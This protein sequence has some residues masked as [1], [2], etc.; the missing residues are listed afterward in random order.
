MPAPVLTIAE[1]RAWERQSWEAGAEEQDVIRRVG[2]RLAQALHGQTPT[3]SRILVVAGRGNNG[4]DAL[5]AA[6][7]LATEFQVERLQILS[8][9]TQLDELEAALQ[10]RPDLLVDGLFGIGLN[11]PLEGPWLGILDRM[12]ASGI[13]IA[14]VDVPSGLD[15]DT[16]SPLG[17]AIRATTTFTVGAPKVG[18][19]TP[20][21]LPFVGRLEVLFD[22]GLRGT[23]TGAS[24]LHW[25][26]PG[27]FPELPPRRVDSHKGSHGHALVIAGSIG[28]SGAA[29]LAARAATRARPGLVS[30]LTLPEAWTP[31]AS[32]LVTAMVHPFEEGHALTTGATAILIGPGLASSSARQQMPAEVVRLWKEFPGPLVVDASA[33]DWVPPHP[34]ARGIRILTPHPGEAGRLLGG[35]AQDVQRDRVGALRQIADRFGALVLLKGHQTLIGGATGPI[36]INPTGNPGLAQGGTGDVLA[37]YLVGL[38]AQPSVATDPLAGCRKAAWDHGLAADYLE[39]RGGAWTSEDLA[40]RLGNRGSDLQWT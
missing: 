17:G 28:Y 36:Y 7:R 38:L 11:R 21:A 26:L 39:C 2:E 18:L 10:R 27:D 25:G 32:Q 23:P 30:V 16:G 40:T 5:A 35:T 22:V 20:D 33:L 4:G 14:S 6:D 15:A 12:N 29:V 13:P 9:E 8:P 1:M 24:P 34:S 3:G 37:G 31:V 19:L